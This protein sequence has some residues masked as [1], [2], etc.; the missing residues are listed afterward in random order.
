MPRQLLSTSSASSKTG[1][2]SCD[3]EAADLSNAVAKESNRSLCSSRAVPTSGFSERWKPRSSDEI[4][5]VVLVV[6]IRAAWIWSCKDLKSCVGSIA[7]LDVVVQNCVFEELEFHSS[8][9]MY[10]CR[11]L[12]AFVKSV[13]SNTPASSKARYILEAHSYQAPKGQTPTATIKMSSSLAPE[14]N[15]V[16]E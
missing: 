16:K 2:R 4:W 13:A 5:P 1:A 9:K 3:I 8:Q 12:S 14:C 7:I 10:P 6:E 11:I 15:E